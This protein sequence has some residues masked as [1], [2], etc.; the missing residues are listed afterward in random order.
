MDAIN[1]KSGPKQEN[2]ICGAF[3][4]IGTSNLEGTAGTTQSGGV[5]L[6]T[7]GD[8]MGCISKVGSDTCK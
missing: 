5:C 6:L 1:T 3:K 4:A 2:K 8:T 7:Q